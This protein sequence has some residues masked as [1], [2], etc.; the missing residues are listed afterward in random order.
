MLNPVSTKQQAFVKH[1]S[2]YH[3]ATRGAQQVAVRKRRSLYQIATREA[4]QVAVRKRRWKI[5][6]L[7]INLKLL[8]FAKQIEMKIALFLVYA[9]IV[10]SAQTVDLNSRESVQQALQK[11]AANMIGW[12]DRGKVKE[13]S[14]STADAFQWY[15]SLF[16]MILIS[17]SLVGL[18]VD[19]ITES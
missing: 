1:L 7:V 17:L 9:R 16:F 15:I 13:T 19:Y 4:Q 14:L 18:K 3:I 2:L 11:M 5:L 8:S 6:H 12:Q 10:L